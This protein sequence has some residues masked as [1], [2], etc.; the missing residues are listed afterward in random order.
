MKISKVIVSSDENPLYLDFWPVISKIWSEFFNIEPILAII[1]NNEEI[2]N[3]I[4]KK[5]GQIIR[6]DIVNDVP[7]YLQ[8]LWVRY[9]LPK[10]YPNDVCMISDIDMIPI[11]KWYFIEQIKNINNEHYVHLNPCLHNYGTLPSCYHVAKGHLFNEILELDEEWQ[12]SILNLNKLNIGRNP[13]GFLEGKNKW[14]SDEEYSS[15]L[16]LKWG[17]KNS[18]K[19]HLIEREDNRRIDRSFWKYDKIL[20]KNNYYYDSHSIRPY[21]DYKKDIDELVKLIM[22]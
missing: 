3:K 19:F 14:F 16:I 18:N 15:D 21:S 12:D 11:S 9:W 8:A 10:N 2:L 13:G 1:S 20:L 6:F 5:Y 22:L 4:E 7:I 17:K